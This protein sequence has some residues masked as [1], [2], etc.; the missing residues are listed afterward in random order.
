[1]KKY[2]KKIVGSLY[3]S[4]ARNQKAR[5]NSYYSAIV[6]A[7]KVINT[8]KKDPIKI[9]Q[10]AFLKD[11]MDSTKLN[12]QWWYN[13]I[14]AGDY[15]INKN[16]TPLKELESSLREIESNIYS[17][18]EWLEI[19]YLSL[20]TGLSHIAYLIQNILIKK[21]NCIDNFKNYNI[22]ELK[23]FA[24]IG[25]KSLDEKITKKALSHI[26]S[27]GSDLEYN[28]VAEFVFQSIFGKNSVQ[29]NLIK[30]MIDHEYLN[31]VKEKSIAIV[32]P[33]P[34]KINKS[35]EINSFDRVIKF[36]YHDDYLLEDS[37]YHSERCDLSYYSGTQVELITKLHKGML[38]EK[39]EWAVIL[40]HGFRV[41]I[42]EKNYN[43]VEVRQEI[44]FKKF[45]LKNL[46]GLPR[47]LLE[48]SMC[49]T[50]KI[51]I[52]NLDLMITKE[53]FNN[54]RLDES[55][56]EGGRLLWLHGAFNHDSLVQYQIVSSIYNNNNN[57]FGD[58]EFE[59]VMNLGA[60]NYMIK[61]QELH[62]LS[63]SL[64]EKS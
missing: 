24:L 12:D 2:I 57:F 51:K 31:Y 47:V 10:N 41:G 49:R 27:F 52:Y 4:N 3:K 29:N 35:D 6:Q 13:F 16:K 54:Y 17:I 50:K 39:L 64:D 43:R 53:R 38:P 34:T 11:G 25:L 32:G 55:R 61:M 7:N 37:L 5:T 58:K 40:N 59:S 15:K 45:F 63:A 42:K 48:L 8:N 18:N 30:G 44:D 28:Q 46:T 19:Y 23:I 33:K 1:M 36:N 22:D 26:N 62:G 56:Y 60:E 20:R 21:I 14:Y 9:I